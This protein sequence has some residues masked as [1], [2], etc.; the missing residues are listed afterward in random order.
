MRSVKTDKNVKANKKSGILKINFLCK[1]GQKTD[2][3]SEDNE[4]ALSNKSF[5]LYKR[6]DKK[7]LNSNNA[8]ITVKDFDNR[9]KIISSFNGSIK[10]GCIEQGKAQNITINGQQH[11]CT[12]KNC[13]PVGHARIKTSV[14]KS[15][16]VFFED[17]FKKHNKTVSSIQNEIN[18]NDKAINI[19]KSNNYDN[20]EENI[21]DLKYNSSD[22][23]KGAYNYGSDT[24]RKVME[25]PS[26]Y[27]GNEFYDKYGNL[28]LKVHETGAIIS[29]GEFDDRKILMLGTKTFTSTNTKYQGE[30]DDDGKLVN[31]DVMQN[32]V[33]VQRFKDGKPVN[34]NNNQPTIGNRNFKFF[35]KNK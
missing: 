30:F 9:D 27:A 34:T 21:E 7:P 2:Y 24:Y 22:N 12:F 25:Y 8:E 3:I 29:E 4:Y 18:E 20:D 13:V 28:R 19:T 23:D 14:G 32:G 6:K 17:E 35:G 5:F 10:N 1:K 11:T 16:E 33:V 15:S 31:G 26:S